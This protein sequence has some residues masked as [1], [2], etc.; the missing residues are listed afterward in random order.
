MCSET[1]TVVFLSFEVDLV[2]FGPS[3]SDLLQQDIYLPFH[4]DNKVKNSQFT[5]GR[6]IFLLLFSNTKW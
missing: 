6:S 5:Q 4:F 1:F 2:Y 3:S